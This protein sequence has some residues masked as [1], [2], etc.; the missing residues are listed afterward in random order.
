[1]SAPWDTLLTGALVFDGSGEPPRREDVAL[2]NGKIAARGAVLPREQAHEVRD[3]REQWLMPGLIDIHT[4]LDLEVELAPGLEEVV[5]H[6]TTAVVVGN[7]SLGAAFGAQRAPGQDPIVDCFARVENIPKHVL[8]RCAD[9]MTWS[10]TGDYLRH[11]D[12]LP[13]GPGIAPLIPHSMLRVQVMGLEQA[14]S[15]S[16]TPAEL[17]RMCALLGKAVSEGYIGFSTDGLPFHYL[18]NDPHRDRRIP[19]QFADYAELK[20]LT[21]ILRDAERVWQATPMPDRIPE[22]LRRFLLSSGRLHGRA[23]R[24]SALAAVD[25]VANPRGISALLGMA[26]LINSPFMRGHFHL[27]A[28]SS[29]FS[30]WADGVTNPIMEELPSTRA[31][32]ALD[33]DDRAGRLALL[34]D[35]AWIA[36]FQADWYRGRRGFDLTRLKMLLGLPP[37]NVSRSLDRFVIDS[38][39]IAAWRGESIA[40]LHARL[41]A[42]QTSGG[43]AG[44]QNADEK[45]FFGDCPS[46]IG[47]A[48]DFFLHLLRCWDKDLR[49][50]TVVAN[51]DP[52]KVR[53]LLFHPHTLPG[54][55][56]SGAHLSNLAFYDGNL[57][58]LKIAQQESTVRVAE[59]VRRLTREP[60]DFFGIAAGSLDTGARGDVVIV[61]PAALAG[62]DSDAHR[63]FIWRED[64]QAQ[65]LVNR[66]DGVVREVYIGGRAAWR[67]GAASALL[68]REKLGSALTFRGRV[69]A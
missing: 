34:S 51:R 15:R 10:D 8:A 14:I 42:F 12:E 1:M 61:D 59:A 27:Q 29:A 52:A 7:C 31:L 4:H 6:G 48:P 32:M 64:L 33:L 69:E 23:L 22:T 11:L 50:Y 5:R 62:Y 38:C 41:L 36:G 37:D 39:P 57:L 26:R 30:I 46:P 40:S 47:E 35:P 53:E 58:T 21:G 3:C 54:F 13:L 45:A 49:W 56:D 67:D 55:N 28:L 25:F 68:G 60:A 17:D 18:A 66:S 2:A 20:R 63:Q 65:Q 9:R 43:T 44:A 16:P 24:V 19:T